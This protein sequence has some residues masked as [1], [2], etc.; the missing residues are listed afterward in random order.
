MRQSMML[1]RCFLEAVLPHAHQSVI[2]GVCRDLRRVHLPSLHFIDKI[3]MKA[4]RSD[5]RGSLAAVERGVSLNPNLEECKQRIN[6][7]L[8]NNHRTITV[9]TLYIVLAA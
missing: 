8:Y 3:A 4:M 9:G 2:R 6:Q 5:S 7:I 1:L